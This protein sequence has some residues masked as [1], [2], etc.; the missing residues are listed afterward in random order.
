MPR[1]QCAVG[2][3]TGWRITKKVTTLYNKTMN[4]HHLKKGFLNVILAL[5]IGALAVCAGALIDKN[6]QPATHSQNTPAA[7]LSNLGTGVRV[8]S[9]NNVT[10][11]GTYRL[12]S[13]ISSTQTTIKLSSFREPISNVPYTMTYL[14]SSLEY[15]TLDPQTNS[16]EFVSFTGITQNSDGT[17]ILT[18]VTR[19]LSR[20]YPY[21]ASSTF[22][23]T[24]SGQSILILS[25][26]PQI[27]NDIY[28][29]IN[30]ASYAGTVDASQNIKGIVEE[31][32]GAEAAA[33]KADGSG[34]TTAPLALTASNASSTRTANTPQIVVSSS[35]DGYI[36][37][38]YVRNLS[39]VILN[40]T[41]TISSPSRTL[42]SFGNQ[43]M[44]RLVGSSTLSGI[45]AT[46]TV[47][48]IPPTSVLIVFIYVPGTDASGSTGTNAALK[49]SFN[50]DSNQNE[51]SFTA[52]TTS[53]NGGSAS[54][55]W[56]GIFM[57]P[58][59]TS[60]LFRTIEAT[61]YNATST[62]K[63]AF[64]NGVVFPTNVSSVPFRTSFAGEWA[65]STSQQITSISL[66]TDS[67]SKLN[68]GTTVYVY[69]SSF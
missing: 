45:N 54:T 27:Y 23:V 30:N 29:Y 52:T 51:Y 34:D 35:T 9:V 58:E 28:N 20:S 36:D 11:G 68:S 42:D 2:F 3:S 50:G 13:S 18:G 39:S 19:G 57:E 15:A 44:W 12:A 60:A 64:G 31:A 62:T 26:A 33:H 25:N 55:T 56:N 66:T 7:S 32:T 49:I 1:S 37:A 59:S 16:S 48:N 67:T 43:F 14:N 10:G 63:A 61:I 21:T 65:T 8:G 53:T 69:G 38:S 17:A 6:I 22:Q 47:S 46:S 24:H 5:I 40:G 41:T 4:K